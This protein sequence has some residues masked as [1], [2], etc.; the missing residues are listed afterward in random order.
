MAVVIRFNTLVVRKSSVAA[1]YPGGL[2]AYRAEYL[3]ESA[4]SY[5]ED[6]H[7]IAHTS[8]AAF[9]AV[10]ERLASSGLAGDSTSA[11]NHCALSQ[12][13]PRP[14]EC[15]WL[16]MSRV[17]GLPVCCLAGEAPGYIVDFKNRRLVR[18]VSEARCPRCARALGLAAAVMAIDA[19]ER[20]DGPLAFVEAEGRPSDAGY[21]ASCGECGTEA[22]CDEHGGVVPYPPSRGGPELRP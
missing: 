20:R 19:R 18:R 8:M 7:L 10:W 12:D 14:P 15:S 13:D 11:A 21:V 22:T 5:Y 6:R 9:H 1:A 16:E 4:S 3:P 2:G 17:C